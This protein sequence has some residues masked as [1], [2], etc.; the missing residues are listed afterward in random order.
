MIDVIIPTRNAPE[1]LALCLVHLWASE[2][3]DQVASVTLLDN[4]S[5]ALGM[6]DVLAATQR[7]GA[8][9]IRHER[10]VGVWAS[11]NRGLAL[12]RS[13]LVLVLTSDILLA[14]RAIL[15]LLRAKR[16]LGER[17]VM[18][19]PDVLDGIPTL[20]WLYQPMPDEYMVNGSHY[21]G[22]CWL[23]DR[24][25]TDRIGWFDSQ[26]YICFGDTDYSQRVLD[27]GL[28][29]GIVGNARCIHLD[30]QSRRHDFTEGEDTQVEMADAERFHEKWQGRPDVLAKHPKLGP[31]Q[32]AITKVGWKEAIPV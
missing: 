26:F 17:Y 20:P 2:G 25:L 32:Y 7:R 5:T 10:N 1:V 24:S 22:A 30:K 13:E 6:D 29:Y 27:A 3:L 21:N 28:R 12:A 16:D 18:L 9:V 15:R 14:P 23:M 19:G 31:V 8:R 4:C 11:V